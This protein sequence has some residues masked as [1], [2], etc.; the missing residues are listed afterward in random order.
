MPHRTSAPRFPDFVQPRATDPARLRPPAAQG[1]E[2]SRRARANG[3]T[4]A[5]AVGQHRVG[6][7][8]FR[9]GGH[10]VPP[11]RPR[12]RGVPAAVPVRTDPACRGTAV[13]ARPLACRHPGRGRLRP[14][15]RRHELELLRGTRSAAPGHRGDDRVHRSAG[16]RARR[17]AACTRPA[18]GGAGGRRRRPAGHARQ[19]SRRHRAR[20][21]LRPD[22]RDVLGRLHPAVQT[23]RCHVRAPGRVGDRAGRRHA[24]HPAGRAD[25]G[26]FGPRPAPRARRGVARGRP[27]VADPLFAGDRRA[28]PPAPRGVRAADEPGTGHGRAGRC[29][30]PR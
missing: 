18:V 2:R 28:A 26:R 5:V 8:R 10:P 9:H 16:G 24:V 11:G 14:G 20:R 23:R 30:R 1:R 4:P 12:R 7:V 3:P 21:R 25:R 13:A 6:P 17:L 27:V 22:R 19:P 29:A 15:A